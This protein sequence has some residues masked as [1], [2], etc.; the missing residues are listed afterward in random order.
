M[1]DGHA[2]ATDLGS[3][4]CTDVTIEHTYGTKQIRN[5]VGLSTDVSKLPTYDDLAT[6][7]RAICADTSEVYYYVST[8]QTWYKQS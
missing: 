5:Y 3:F 1:I 2:G 6:G 8:G 4:V 7:S